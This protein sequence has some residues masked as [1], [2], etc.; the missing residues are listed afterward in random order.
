MSDSEPCPQD[1]HYHHTKHTIAV[2]LR[3]FPQGDLDMFGI[4]S[5][6]V[7]RDVVQ[8]N[9]SVYHYIQ[10]S[11][12]LATT[13][14]LLLLLRVLLLLLRVVVVVRIRV[15]LSNRTLQTC[16]VIVLSNRP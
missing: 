13:Y 6:H 8:V 3:S 4:M 9:I 5:L 14:K 1:D 16:V 2:A 7:Q 10:G 15:V 12:D 11:D